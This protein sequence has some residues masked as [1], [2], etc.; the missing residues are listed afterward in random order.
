[1]ENLPGGTVAQRLFLPRFVPLRS[2][3]YEEVYLKAYDNVSEARASIGCYLNFYN[4]RLQTTETTSTHASRK[5]LAC[6]RQCPGGPISPTLPIIRSAAREIINC[7][8]SSLA[9]TV[10]PNPLALSDCWSRFVSRYSAHAGLAE[11][12]LS[13]DFAITHAKEADLV[14]LRASAALVGHV[15]RHCDAEPVPRDEGLAHADAMPGLDR[16]PE[17]ASLLP[18][19]GHARGITGPPGGNPSGSMLAASEA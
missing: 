14:Q 17:L 13:H 15:Q 7:L 2:V 10:S 6:S 3:K 18:D 12:L 9:S 11:K 1:M 19:G 16:R 4:R 5:C 8:S